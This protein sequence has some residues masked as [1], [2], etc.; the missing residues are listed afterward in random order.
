M[1]FMLLNVST[2]RYE[3]QRTPTVFKSVSLTNTGNIWTPT[4]GTFFRLMW[5]QVQIT[6]NSTL[7][8]GGELTIKLQD[9]AGNDIGINFIDYLQ[10][11]VPASA[12]GDNHTVIDLPFNGYRSTTVNNILVANFSAALTGGHVGITAIGTEETAG[13]V[14]NY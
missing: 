12:S 3:Y 9:G 5:I 2:N 8:G 4:T 1:D 14:T 6:E 7:S 13:E 11:N 10:N